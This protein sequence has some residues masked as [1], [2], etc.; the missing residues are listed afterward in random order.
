LKFTVNN[1]QKYKLEKFITDWHWNEASHV[2]ANELGT[3][4]FGFLD[5]LSSE[6]SDRSYRAH[7]GN[8]WHIGILTC[9][10][11]YYEK[12]SVDIIHKPPFFELEFSR[13]SSDSDY[14]INSYR[15]TCKRLYQYKV[16]KEYKTLAPHA[17]DFH[18][19]LEDLIFG[20][21]LLLPKGY[22][23]SKKSPNQYWE[24]ELES[25]LNLDLHTPTAVENEQLLSEKL[26][27]LVA[28]LDKIA[29]KLGDFPVENSYRKLFLRD[30]L[31]SDIQLIKKVA[32]N[33]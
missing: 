27:D 18:E 24:T 16:K 2:F 23:K 28:N 33:R 22:K 10:Y 4:L 6:V 7:L 30:N 12:F 1:N 21:D 11:G 13:K 15:S 25:I 5:Y 31:L 32:S 29:I 9:Q 20:F 19:W 3:F 14:A 26:G 17:P 8:V